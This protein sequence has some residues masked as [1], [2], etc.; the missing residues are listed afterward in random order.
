LYREPLW[1]F[2]RGAPFDRLSQLAGKRIGVGPPGSGKSVVGRRL[3][4]ARGAEF[5]D[6]D[7]AIEAIAGMPVARIFE[8]EGEAGFR[9]RESAAIVALGAPDA[10]PRLTRVVAAGG[11]AVVDPRNRWRLFVG[12]RTVTLEQ[13]RIVEGG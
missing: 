5:V 12:R 3:A 2:Y 4:R 9:A 1:I 10:S 8:T 13:G 7:S 11:G 6:L